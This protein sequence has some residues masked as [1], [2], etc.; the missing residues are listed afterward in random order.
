M[1]LPMV[2]LNVKL[3]ID[4]ERSHDRRNYRSFEEKCQDNSQKVY[5]ILM[6]PRIISADETMAVPKRFLKKNAGPAPQ[7]SMEWQWE[8]TLTPCFRQLRCRMFH[9]FSIGRNHVIISNQRHVC[10]MMQPRITMNHYICTQACHGCF[11]GIIN[12]GL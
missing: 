1:N 2:R 11:A 7:T 8:A 4:E 12:R 6:C 5:V 3:W 9:P 10:L